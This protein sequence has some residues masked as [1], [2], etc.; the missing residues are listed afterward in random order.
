MKK[1]VIVVTG[2]VFLGGC[3]AIHV[4]K[5][6]TAASGVKNCKYEI[7]ESSEYL[8]IIG[9][10]HYLSKLDGNDL[11]PPTE[12]QMAD[13]AYPSDEEANKLIL[14]HNK[15]AQCRVQAIESFAN[16][17]PGVIPT[18]IEGYKLADEHELNLIAKKISWGEYAKQGVQNYNQY[19]A[20]LQK[21]FL[22]AQS[23]RERESDK[24]ME[25]VGDVSGKILSGTLQV[26]L[27][28]LSAWSTQQQAMYRNYQSSNNT[29]RFLHTDCTANATG[30][31]QS[32]HCSTY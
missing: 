8:S 27:A 31:S 15:V 20:T 30:S 14:I 25:A 21:A 3:Q 24:T 29:N 6:A 26:A 7:Q 5:L 17:E 19:R 13:T 16:V 12:S 11:V 23:T 28:A 18:L 9:N 10:G 4:A 2:F 1:I 22:E 32:I